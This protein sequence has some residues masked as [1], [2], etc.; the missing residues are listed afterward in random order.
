MELETV[1]PYQAPAAY[2]A[3]A[4]ADGAATTVRL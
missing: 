2:V 1:N 3:D 4:P